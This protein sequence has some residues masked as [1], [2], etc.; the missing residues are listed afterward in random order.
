LT[1][2]IQEDRI[3]TAYYFFA[4]LTDLFLSLILWFIFDEDKATA[5]VVEGN[6]AYAVVDVIKAD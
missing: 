5:V 3:N 4:G 6:R 2:L 1:G